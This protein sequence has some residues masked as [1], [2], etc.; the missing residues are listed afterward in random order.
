MK[1]YVIKR[2][3]TGLLTILIVF[4]INFIIIRLAPGDPIKTL[5]G[6]END[7]PVLRAALEEKYGLDKPLTVQFALYLKTALGGD[8]GTSIIYNRPVTEMI[9][10]KIG[11]TLL[12]VLTAA[13]LALIIGTSMGIQAARREGSFIDVIFS[14][15]SYV[16]N[17]MPSFWL[18][19]MLI[20]IFASKL[21]M[22]PSCGMTNTRASYTGMNYV[23]DVLVHMILPV[24]TLL[25]IQIPI[26]FR[27]AKSSVLQVSNEDF[28]ITLRA[29][30]MGER[31]IFN[32]YIF[33]NAIL[34]TITIFGISLAYLI[35]GVAL[36]EIVFAWPGTGRLVL[37]AINQRDYPT[38]M[39]IYLIMSISVAV[40]MVLVD[41]VYAITSIY[42]RPFNIF[43]IP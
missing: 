17:S 18:G 30:G 32:K 26:Y 20:I 22:L 1:K 23:L 33:R 21:S 13:V 16:L 38:L 35:T 28:I 39:G 11:A 40:V 31:K 9:A 5:M 43:S 14:G 3:L 19:L 6:K 37:T 4:A 12:L 41:I 15:L 27:I 2:I 7:D 8:L 42:A 10:E 29:T 25:L 36:I 24:G 34:P